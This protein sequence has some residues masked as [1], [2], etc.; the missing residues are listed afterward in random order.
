MPAAQKV[1]FENGTY[2]MLL[3]STIE[4]FGV[5]LYTEFDVD[6]VTT[7]SRLYINGSIGQTYPRAD[8]PD[9]VD[10]LN[11]LVLAD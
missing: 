2:G 3:K 7:P 4:V 9:L 8:K 6:V 11:C 10:W 5:T 1:S